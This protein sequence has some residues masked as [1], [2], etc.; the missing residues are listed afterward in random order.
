MAAGLPTV[1]ARS[2]G[3]ADAVPE[4]GLYTPGDIEALARR[5]TALYGDA[6]AGERALAVARERHA[7]AVVA[8][9]LRELYDR[10]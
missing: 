10:N 4:E 7:P 3:L 8:A 6:E 9:T 2:G 1:A 5:L